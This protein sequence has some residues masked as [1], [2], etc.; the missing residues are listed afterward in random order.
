MGSFP[1]VSLALLSQLVWG[2][3]CAQDGRRTVRLT[4]LEWPPYTTQAMVHDGESSAV[5]RSALAAVG[6]RLE[7]EFF[8]WK[9]AV[10]LTRM[11]SNFDGY[12]PEY[13]SDATAQRCLLSDTIGS[14]A[15]GF[16]QLRARP[17]QWT[18]LDDLVQYRIGVVQDYVNSDE[19]DLRIAQRK[20]SVDLA[21]DDTQNLRKLAAGR[22]E[23]AV[24]DQRVFDYLLQHDPQLQPY[25][26][27]LAF[28]SRPLEVKQLYICFRNNATG[29]QFRNLVNAGLKKLRGS[30]R[31]TAP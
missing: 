18:T 2:D 17:V 4:T 3:T 15:V 26:H 5:V 20:Q 29:K 27:T 30:T 9:R 8:P 12:F 21:R 24:I 22:I 31:P 25:R 6:Y 10:A 13:R 19:F 28:N 14:G 1:I 7:V 11:R 23:L 16:A